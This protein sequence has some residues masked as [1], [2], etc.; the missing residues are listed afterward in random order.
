M[1]Q[2]GLTL[3]YDGGLCHIETSPLISNENQWTSFYMIGALR[4]E[5]VKAFGLKYSR[6]NQVKFVEDNL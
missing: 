4:Y 2:S 1:T 6:M 3:F 5:R